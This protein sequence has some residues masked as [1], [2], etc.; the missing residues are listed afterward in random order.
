MTPASDDPRETHL[1]GL[2]DRFLQ[3][4]PEG[5]ESDLKLWATG[6]PD[7]AGRAE[8]VEPP[9]ERIERL[10]RRLHARLPRAP[11]APGPRAQKP[12]DPQQVVEAVGAHLDSVCC[13]RPARLMHVPNASA[14]A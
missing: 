3:E 12:P 10:V 11:R 6:Q 14:L 5:G 8:E 9:A 4:V 13:V 1:H 2:L 7:L